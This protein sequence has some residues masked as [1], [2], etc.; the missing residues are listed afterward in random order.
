MCDNNERW[1]GVF[2]DGDFGNQLVRVFFVFEISGIDEEAEIWNRR[3]FVD[4]F[5]RET[6][7]AIRGENGCGEVTSGG[8]AKQAN[9]L[10]VDL[11]FR[12]L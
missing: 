1:R 3:V 6:H 10:R 7:R 9:A 4:L 5:L 12:S 11:P 2:I 8:E